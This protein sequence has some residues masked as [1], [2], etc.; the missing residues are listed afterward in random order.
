MKLGIER[1]GGYQ[2][3]KT[4]YVSL[5]P[6]PLM[7]EDERNKL[8]KLALQAAQ[9]SGNT[10]TKLEEDINQIVYELFDLT[11]KEIQLVH[12]SVNRQT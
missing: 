8:N 1:R 10:L 3:F 7:R 5:I 2:E 6:I 9:S 11:S 4:Q 12:F